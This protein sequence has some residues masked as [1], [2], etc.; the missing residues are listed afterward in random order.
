M[1]AHSSFKK[2]YFV[3]NW[4]HT[5]FGMQTA[6]FMEHIARVIVMDV[7]DSVFHFLPLQVLQERQQSD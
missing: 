1:C 5:A 6:W 4:S 3:F 2:N 7:A